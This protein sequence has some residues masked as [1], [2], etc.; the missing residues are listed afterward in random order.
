MNGQEVIGILIT[1]TAFASYINYKFTK[2]HTSIGL[3]LITVII[4]FLI[5][6]SGNL[7]WDVDY[8]SQSLL[9]G[10]SFNETFLHGMLGFL[11]FAGSLHINT[12]ELAKYKSTIALL[13][14]LGVAISTILV[15]YSTYFLTKFIGLN[16]AKEYCLLFGAIISPTDPIAVLGVLKTAK[17]PKALE[18]KIAGES[19][20][21][22]G[23]AIVL[24]FILLAYAEE[25]GKQKDISEIFMMF[26]REG[27]GGFI[28]GA[29]IGWISAKLLQTINDYQIAIIITLAVVSGGYVLAHSIL[30]VSGPICMAVSGLIIGSY[31]KNGSMSKNTIFRLDSFWEL[32]DEVLNAILFVLIGLEFLHL[33]LSSDT[34]LTSNI[35]VTIISIICISIF[36]RWVSV[37]FPIGFLSIFQKYSPNLIAC[38][39]WGG[40]RG[41]IS[42]ALA[43]S[44]SPSHDRDFLIVMTYS[45]VLFSIMVQGL[46]MGSL[47]KK[48]YSK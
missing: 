9:Y 14:T 7:G 23:M 28:L 41:G 5:A 8:F 37:I 31:I 42:I 35:G 15:G 4:S 17:A 11:L 47:V 1:I 2:L 34:T 3:T 30:H 39:T 22:D 45:V 36:C 38:M 27:I 32:L 20:F 16:I 46:T 48:L 18:M 10:I 6:G 13:A 29:I 33:L 19:L 40:L 44:V 26:L 25:K 43:L 12:L 21:N 24:F